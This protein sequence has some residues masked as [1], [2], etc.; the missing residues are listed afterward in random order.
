MILNCDMQ[1]Q[2]IEEYSFLKYE[3]WIIAG[4]GFAS[5]QMFL[6]GQI[7]MQIKLVAGDSAG[8]VL[9]FYVRTIYFI[10]YL[11]LTYV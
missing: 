4:A 10:F 2:F 3:Y 8:T 1:P 7:D 5:N 6:F 9:A 11:F